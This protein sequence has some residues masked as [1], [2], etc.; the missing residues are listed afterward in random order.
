[1]FSKIEIIGKTVVAKEPVL[2]L[3]HSGIFSKGTMF[4]VENYKRDYTTTGQWTCAGSGQYF[5]TLEEINTE[6]VV[7]KQGAFKSLFDFKDTKEVRKIIVSQDAL[8]LL[9]SFVEE[10]F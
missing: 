5:I 9:F 1:M 8:L 10:E 4:K 2:S 3:G 6:E 7:T